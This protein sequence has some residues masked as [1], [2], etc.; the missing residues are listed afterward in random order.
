M[1]IVR[2][3]KGMSLW[4]FSTLPEATVQENVP[5]TAQDQGESEGVLYSRGG[6]Q[7]VV[8]FMHPRG[9]MR[10][11][12]A[13]PALLEAGF[14]CF[15]Q[16]GRWVNNDTALIH[17]QIVLDVAEALRF[18][19]D[20]KRFEK[21]VLF[22]NSGGG[23]LYSLYQAQAATAK[24]ERLKDTA[25]GDPFDLGRFDMPEADAL[26]QLAT[27]LGQGALLEA[28]I[29]PSVTDEND[30]YSRDPLLDMYDPDNGFVLAPGETR[31]GEPFLARYR[32]AQARRVQRIDA[33]ARS[34]IEATR[35]FLKRLGAENLDELP[36]SDRRFI[37]R[38]AF[39][40]SYL[41]VFRTEAHPGY[42]DLSI[43][44]SRRDQGSFMALR[45]DLF[46]MMAPGFGKLI[47]PQ[48][49]LSTWSG[50]SSRALTL[51]CSDKL[52]VATLVISFAG[53]NV[54]FSNATSAIYEA[55]AAK[56]KQLMTFDG[57]HVGLPTA[58][59]PDKDG[60]APALA[61]VTR[62]LSERFPRR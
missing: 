15:A 16:A 28:C 57:D 50:H 10:R 40:S 36:A 42:A 45:P 4:S 34:R 49:W 35:F 18:L 41:Q 39:G 5:L 13:I 7:T 29:D 1:Q 17:E 11:H 6:E 30:L 20:Q 32:A 46:N 56:D 55:S 44:P 19:R 21:V 59:E 24:N 8:C 62:W 22:G 33:I 48:A 43:Y 31:Y 53:D 9:D 38:R 51:R 2:Y 3:L 61:A 27:H 58:R 23:A 25:A 52:T 47:T 12:Y 26:I 54:V 14:A 37:E 60:R